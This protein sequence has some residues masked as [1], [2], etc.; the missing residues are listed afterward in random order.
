MESVKWKIWYHDPESPTYC[1]TWSSLDGS[2]LDSPFQ[3]VICITQWVDGGRHF[4]RVCNGDY[5]AI[6]E[7][8]KWIGIDSRGIQDRRENNIKF[9][10]LKQGRWV[11]TDRFRD[12]MERAFKDPDFNRGQ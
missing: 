2:A 3:G 12:I 1:R 5:Y 6:D 11:N 7:E 9:H 4:E 10:S 8:D